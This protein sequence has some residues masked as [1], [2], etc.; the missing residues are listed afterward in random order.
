M[1]EK[2]KKSTLNN[3]HRLILEKFKKEKK[4]LPKYKLDLEKIQKR[5]D[6]LNKKNNIKC[7]DKEIETK[8]NLKEQ[9]KV[10]EKK[11]KNIEEQKEK[12]DYFLS[13]FDLLNDYFTNRQN[14]SDCEEPSEP[15]EESTVINFFK[16]K[17]DNQMSMDNFINK[18]NKIKNS[19]L[20]EKYLNKIEPKYSGKHEFIKNFDLCPQCKIKKMLIQNEGRYVCQGCGRSDNIIID[21]EKPSYKEAMS[22][23]CSSLKIEYIIFINFQSRRTTVGVKSMLPTSLFMRRHTLLREPPKDLTTTSF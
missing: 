16:K 1:K 4:K 23:D 13:T 22:S 17:D 21:S 9:L 3:H 19:D 14:C 18:K 8:F 10:L 12:N 20:Y 2:N 15:E 7:S 11:I 5:F 6:K